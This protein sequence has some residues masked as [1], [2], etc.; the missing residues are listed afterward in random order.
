MPPEYVAPVFSLAG[1]MIVAIIV[2]AFAIYNRG[3]GNLESKMPT[4]QQ[5]WARQTEQETRYEAKFKEI[6]DTA[7][8]AKSEALAAT[9]DRD[10][11][12]T[13]FIGLRDVFLAFVERAKHGG[14]FELTNQ[15]HLALELPVT[16]IEEDDLAGS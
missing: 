12:K 11:Y 7:D 5:I 2:G 13:A 9:R 15:E 1:G 6:S 4:V 8:E 3:R 10:T 16:N 14:P